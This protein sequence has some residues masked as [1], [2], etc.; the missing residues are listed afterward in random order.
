[1]ARKHSWDTVREFAEWIADQDATGEPTSVMAVMN[2]VRRNVRPVCDQ[3][4]T[5]VRPREVG[6]S[7]AWWIGGPLCDQCAT[8]VR[9]VC[10]RVRL[11]GTL[12]GRM[13]DH[14]TTKDES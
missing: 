3:C 2:F 4:A 1:A 14:V 7:L 11:G 13:V 10:D 12:P 8:G 5:G 9:P 6:R